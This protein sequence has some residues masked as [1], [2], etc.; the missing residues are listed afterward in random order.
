MMKALILIIFICFSLCFSAE[1]DQKVEVTK[2]ILVQNG[3]YYTI[4]VS[5]RRIPGVQGNI[6]NVILTDSLPDTVDLVSGVLVKRG[7]N[8]KKKINFINIIFAHFAFI[9]N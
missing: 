6:N 9:T 7:A 3:N 2:S 8:V 4:S 1:I 5:F